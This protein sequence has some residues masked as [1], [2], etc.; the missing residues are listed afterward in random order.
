MKVFFITNFEDYDTEEGK[1]E[2]QKELHLSNGNHKNL[3]LMLFGSSK[4]TVSHRIFVFLGIQII[5]L[6]FHLLI[7]LAKLVR[8]RETKLMVS[9]EKKNVIIASNKLENIKNLQQ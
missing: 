3:T 9:S 2:L 7:L 8:D 1:K 4:V 6:Q 5:C